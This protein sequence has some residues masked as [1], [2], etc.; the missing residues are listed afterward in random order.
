MNIKFGLNKSPKVQIGKTVI[1]PTGGDRTGSLR[2]GSSIIDP[3][4]LVAAGPGAFTG[5]NYFHVP[6]WG[7]YYFITNIESVR[8]GMVQISGHV[9][10]LESAKADIK[11]QYCIVETTQTGFNRDLNDGTFKIYQNRTVINKFEFPESFGPA[12]WVL[13]LAGS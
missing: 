10:V 9:D 4:I 12:S 2:D 3:V 13:A 6:D 5:I 1:W 11:K 7:R 8:N